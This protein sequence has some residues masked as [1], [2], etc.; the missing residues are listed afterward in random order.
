MFYGWRRVKTGHPEFEKRTF[1]SM[2]NADAPPVENSPPERSIRRL[3]LDRGDSRGKD[4]ADKLDVE[5]SV[6]D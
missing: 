5:H 1:G 4:P 6:L 3:D 2:F